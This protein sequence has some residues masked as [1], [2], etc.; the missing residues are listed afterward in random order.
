MSTPWFVCGCPVFLPTLTEVESGMILRVQRNILLILVLMVT[1]SLNAS[2][3]W[4]GFGGAT[5]KEEV[6]LHDGRKIVVERHVEQ[7][8][9]HEIGQSSGYVEQ[10]LSFTLPEI[11]E[12]VIWK[13]HF[14]EDIGGSSFLPMLVDI[15]QGVAYVVATN[16]GCLS[17]NKW[18][19]PNPPYVVFK[20]QNKVWERIALG[21]LPAE[22]N[23]PNIILSQPDIE[24][25]RLGK[26]FVSAEEVQNIINEYK[27][28][29]YR[30]VMREPFATAPWGC[31]EMIH[32]NNGWEGL[33]FFSLKGNYEACNQYC[34][35]R[36]VVP[37]NCPCTKLFK[38][39]KS[40][41]K[42]PDSN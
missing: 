40:E 26:R 39:K 3:G 10:H 31:A 27:Q 15:Y 35:Q 4:F 18:G 42:A 2:A 1:F 5:W 22:I 16:M 12:R 30:S 14:S 25:E 7:G 33:G 36:A 13:D 20:Y 32:T 6:L 24:I 8:G 9:R 17:Y 19:R 41:S 23:L 37:E 38:E 11:G 28:P 21:K 34:A 29:V